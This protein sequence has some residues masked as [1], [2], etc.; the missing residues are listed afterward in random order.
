MTETFL[1]DQFRQHRKRLHGIAYRM[2]GTASD[3][4]DAVQETWLRLDSSDVASIDNLAGWL[5]TVTARI[6]LN[7][8]RSRAA[9]REE[10]LD[11]H[12]PDPILQRATA[13]DPEGEAVLA[14]SVGLALL[15]VLDTL[16]PAE[17]L[18][19]VLHDVF[20]VPFD[21]LAALLD[22]TPDATRQLASR[23]RRR[24]RVATV[25]DSDRG[26]QR[27]VVE[28][29]FAAARGGDIGPLLAV[30]DPE[31]VMRVDGGP[32]LPSGVTRGAN[33][34]ARRA[35]MFAR[36]DAVLVPVLATGS[37]A[38]VVVVGG[39]VRSIM[40]FTVMQGRITAIDALNDPDRIRHVDLSELA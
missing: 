32:T 35:M 19:F 23:A 16:T 4:D 29:F 17:R 34:I 8:L 11:A 18:A 6:C 31:A 1:S 12:I 14:D 21:E 36:P 22:R 39:E 7:M 20:A 30:L 10:S 38:V 9:R 15:L 28:A 5:T 27:E 26:R 40:S 24:V 2:L 37:P 13:S 33:V 3:A 25:P